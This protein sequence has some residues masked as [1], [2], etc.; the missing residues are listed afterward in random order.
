MTCE[1][2]ANAGVCREKRDISTAQGHPCPRLSTPA[3]QPRRPTL[4]LCKRVPKHSAE[5][6]CSATAAQFSKESSKESVQVL[7]GEHTRKSTD[8]RHTIRERLLPHL[9]DTHQRASRPH[10]RAIQMHGALAAHAS[11][12]AYVTHQRPAPLFHRTRGR[13]S[14]HPH[15]AGLVFFRL[16][17]S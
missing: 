10:V 5:R 4:I 6:A 7:A 11:F 17:V 8:V 13:G 9:H 12:F 14:A 1:F 15:P 2:K 16:C 3:R